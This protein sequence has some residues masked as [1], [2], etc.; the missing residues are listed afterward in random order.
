MKKILY[1]A[2]V[3]SVMAV[4]CSKMLDIEPTD[5]ISNE[6]AIKDK[7][8]VEK[9]ITGAYDV[10]QN[11]GLYGRSRVV[12]GD[13]SADNLSWS[14]TTLDY[15]Q[16][17]NNQVPIDNS[18]I[19]GMWS[20]AYDGINRANNILF[21]LPGISDMTDAERNAY[22]G[23]ALFIRALLHFNLLNYFGGVPVKTTP[24]MSLDDIDL[25]RNTVT[26]VYLQIIDDLI[27]AEIKLPPPGQVSGGRAN[28]FSATALLARVYLTRFHAEEKA[29]FADLAI[30]K[31]G[32]VILEGGFSLASD[33]SAL[34]SGNTGEIIFQ[35]LFSVQDRNRYAEYF[36]P[37]SLTGRYEIAP[38]AALIES[39]DPAD[40]IR[41]K[42]T[43]AFDS[44]GTPYGY[45]YRQLSEGSDPV[46]VI[47]MAE[48]YL[49]RAEALAYTNGDPG[50][51]RDD[52][53]IIRSRAGLPPVIDQTY[54]ELRL[55]IETERRFEFAFEGH[56][57]FDLVR[58][59]R[60][61]AVLGIEAYKMLFPI[62]LSEMT[63]NGA[64]EQNFGY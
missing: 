34:F 9:A 43:I 1:I 33:Y 56:R 47:R 21:A 31:A 54:P 32:K 58:T 30:E 60:A 18:F 23:Q 50:A 16:I 42:T 41:F 64:M 51:I 4:S 37:R 25:P 36:F 49:I 48:M 24:T 12:L 15:A 55:A 27:A 5:A 2:F 26:E 63:T 46:F 19:E 22:E 61:P 29:E 14:G 57:W 7:A 28:A 20:G 40:S 45:K 62:P 17:D 35:V 13:L 52:I 11:V 3:L 53:N 8:G 59:G 44:L 38:S 6:E 10:L 39:F